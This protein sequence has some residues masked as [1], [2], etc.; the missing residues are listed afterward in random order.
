M[1]FLNK[2]KGI[3]YVKERI[4]QFVRE[5]ECLMKS[6]S[7]SHRNQE[8]LAYAN[9]LVHLSLNVGHFTLEGECI[10]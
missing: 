6:M 10:W 1:F 8:S 2:S 4:Y 5:L 3:K 9:R 7:V